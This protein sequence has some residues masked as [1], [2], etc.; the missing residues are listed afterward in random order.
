MLPDATGFTPGVK[1]MGELKLALL[2]PANGSSSAHGW[3][4]W[5]LTRTGRKVSVR[6]RLS[7]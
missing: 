1:K 6:S 5:K 4:N 3:R 2:N 7:I